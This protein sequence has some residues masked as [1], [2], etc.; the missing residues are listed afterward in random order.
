MLVVLFITRCARDD[1]LVKISHL[2]TYFMYMF[3]LRKLFTVPASVLCCSKKM[4][5]TCLGVF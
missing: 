4:R 2:T 3:S 1:V 5:Q